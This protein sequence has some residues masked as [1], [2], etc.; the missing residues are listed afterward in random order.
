MIER[1]A[2]PLV[3]ATLAG[4]AEMHRIAEA[5]Y[6]VKANAGIFR[7]AMGALHEGGGIATEPQCIAQLTWRT[8]PK[9]SVLTLRM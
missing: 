7:L 6:L 5:G 4:A 8:L 1:R 3:E 2:C 9:S